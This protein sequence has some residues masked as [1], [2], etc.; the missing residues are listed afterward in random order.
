M[1]NTGIAEKLRNLGNVMI[2]FTDELLGFFYFQS[3]PVIDRAGTGPLFENAA[4][5]GA[6]Q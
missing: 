3:N 4:Q 6:A 2:T 5:I 1:M